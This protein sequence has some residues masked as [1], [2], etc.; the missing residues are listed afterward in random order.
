MNRFN[1]KM[2]AH[3]PRY[4]LSHIVFHYIELMHILSLAT[5][6]AKKQVTT[7]VRDGNAEE[8]KL[9]ERNE[10]FSASVGMAVSDGDVIDLEDGTSQ[11]EVEPD[12]EAD[13]QVTVEDETKKENVEESGETAEQKTGTDF[14]DVD[15]KAPGVDSA[16]LD[17]D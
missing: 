14:V 10:P 2:M 3:L 7:E 16:L 8:M 17:S 12:K 9:L 6:S 15:L 5:S 1:S 13:D 4:V 11:K